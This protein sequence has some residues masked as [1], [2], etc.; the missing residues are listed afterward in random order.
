MYKI[1]SLLVLLSFVSVTAQEELNEKDFPKIGVNGN[2]RSS[3]PQVLKALDN[4]GGKDQVWDYSTITNT[5]DLEQVFWKPISEASAEAIATFP[6]ATYFQTPSFINS[7]T[8]FVLVDKSSHKLLGYKLKTDFL[9]FD[10][11]IDYYPYP[12]KYGQK[13]ESTFSYDYSGK[14]VG[15]Y[16]VVYDGYGKLQLPD[17]TTEN[18][19]RLKQVTRTVFEDDLTDTTISTEY[20]F[21]ERETGRLLF[22]LTEISAAQN[23]EEK[24]YIY[25][26]FVSPIISS[27]NE[28]LSA[29][30]EVYP[31][32]STNFIKVDVPSSVILDYSI[33]DINGNTIGS[34]SYTN[35]IDISGLAAGTYFVKANLV[36]NEVVLKKFIKQ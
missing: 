18:V 25:Q 27:V 29:K 20:Q 33:V 5:Q 4:L 22:T 12:M 17:N 9:K 21:L 30:T 14:A 2:Y 36:T 32:P 1:L 35:M 15:K 26:Y 31:N 23:P 7:V 8:N 13:Y 34:S 16:T 10:K 11:P 24:I 3:T 19:F 28:E 6:N